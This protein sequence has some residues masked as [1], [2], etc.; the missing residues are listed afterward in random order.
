MKERSGSIVSGCPTSRITTSRRAAVPVVAL[1]VRILP[2]T[3][4]CR[5]VPPSSA[6]SAR[7]CPNFSPLGRRML[8]ST[9]PNSG[10]SSESAPSARRM[11][12]TGSCGTGTLSKKSSARG[13]RTSPLQISTGS[14]I[15]AL[16]DGDSRLI[17]LK[18]CRST[19]HCWPLAMR[20]V[21]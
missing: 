10:L 6:S 9:T 5:K 17:G 3:P 18:I 2:P 14:M 16:A 12:A 15:R 21:A 20:S 13:R 8:T 7:G 1:Y 4:T 19:S 11:V